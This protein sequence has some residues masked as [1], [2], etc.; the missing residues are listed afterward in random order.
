M[1]D[2]DI[3]EKL[4]E[5]AGGAGHFTKA[6]G[7]SRQTVWEWRTRY[8]D[9]ARIRIYLYAEDVGFKLPKDFLRRAL[10]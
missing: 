5:K 7:V 8:T 1:T 4:I 3:I 10:V 2:S 9:T 6:M